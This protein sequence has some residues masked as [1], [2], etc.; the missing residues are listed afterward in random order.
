MNLSWL[1]RNFLVLPQLIFFLGYVG[2][3]VFNLLLFL[4]FFIGMIFVFNELE[5]FK[6][7]FGIEGKV[8]IL[9][10]VM[11]YFSWGVSGFLND[12]FSLGFKHWAV[13]FLSSFL[14]LYVL[15]FEYES[16]N[17]K[18][19]T[20]QVVFVAII[21]FFLAILLRFYFCFTNANCAADSFV[22]VMPIPILTSIIGLYF[23]SIFNASWFKWFVIFSVFPLIL[24]AFGDSR[25]ELLMF[26]IMMMVVNIF[27][28]R[29]FVVLSVV[30]FLSP[31]LVIFLTS[32][33]VVSHQIVQSEDFFA[34]LNQVSSSR[35]VI[36]TRAISSNPDNIIF[37]SGIDNTMTFL[38]KNIHGSAL[39]NAYLEIWYETGFLG[40]LLWCLLIGYLIKHIKFMY[41]ADDCK[42]RD[43]YSL[44][45][46]GFCAILVAGFFDKGYMSIY[47]T[48]Y[49]YYFAVLLFVFGRYQK[50]IKRS[51]F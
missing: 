50:N 2:R 46:A 38:P 31:I 28:Y 47:F 51:N 25:T 4:Y 8:V 14:V 37:G 39:H 7:R 6:R 41:L 18:H 24:V 48:F 42:N 26:L 40:L 45:F 43:I 22:D 3:G 30:I 9:L 12:A 17:I 29:K 21:L 19:I 32:F 13:S 16:L 49:I 44:F 34:T 23:I 11:L 1:K 15:L 35:L 27:Y 20:N 5:N 33:V 10:W 36:W